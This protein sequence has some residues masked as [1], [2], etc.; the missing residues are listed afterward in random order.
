MALHVYDDALFRAQFPAFAD[1]LIYPEVLI[2][3]YFDVATC[4]INA[5]DHCRLHDDCL[6]YALNLMTAHL[7]ALNALDPSGGGGVG[8]VSSATIDKVSVTTQI[9]TAAG[10]FRQ[11]LIRTGFGQQLSALLSI[12]A[13]GGFMVGGSPERASIRQAGGRFPGAFPWAR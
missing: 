4:Y 5:Y 6:Q 7:L 12:K 8:A 2:A 3:M 9:P 11:F 13:V 10:P 1:G